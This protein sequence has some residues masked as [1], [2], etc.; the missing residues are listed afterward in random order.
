MAIFALA[1]AVA[2]AAYYGLSVRNSAPLLISQ[3]GPAGSAMPAGAQIDGATT[4]AQAESESTAAPA[5]PPRRTDVDESALRYF[6]AQGDIE[7]LHA[8]IARLR[9]L[10][11]DWLP[12]D[13][14]LDYSR[15]GDPR[16]EALWALYAEGRYDE[17]EA[18]IAR[19]Q[20]TTP[21]FLPPQVLVDS[22]R[23]AKDREALVKASNEGAFATVVDVAAR[24][25]Q[26]LTCAE[27]DVMWRLAEAFAQTD[28]ADR[29]ADAYRFILQNCDDPGERQATVIKASAFLDTAQIESLLMLERRGD[30]GQGEFE[31]VRDDLARAMVSRVANEPDTTVAASYLDRLKTAARR[32]GEPDDSILLGWYSYQRG[33][34]LQARDW[35]R[36]AL[37]S[38]KSPEA[39]QGLA[40]T[41]AELKNYA[42]AE[43]VLYEYRNVS[44]DTIKVYLATVAN[45]LSLEPPKAIAAD[46]LNRMAPVVIE[47]RDVVSAE[48]FGWYAHYL[49]QETTAIDWFRAALSWDPEHEPAAYGLALALNALN[50]DAEVAQ[51]QETWRGRSER[52]ANLG[53]EKDETEPART[54][55]AS[56]P[57][58]SR[59]TTT[60]TRPSTRRAAQPAGCTTTVDMQTISPESALDRGWCLMDLNRTMEAVQAFDRA[61]ASGA[62]ATRK[63]AAYGKS[64]AYLRLKMPDK[65]A[66]A[67]T[68]APQE[69]ARAMELQSAILA[70]RAIGAFR[71]GRYHETII[72]LDQRAR[73]APERQDLMVL[74]A[75]A[76]HNIGRRSDAKRIFQALASVGNKEAMRALGDL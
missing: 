32:D 13:D 34:Y 18:E 53:E 16:I 2:S 49:G 23:L 68:A 33:M 62:Q 10:Y 5:P 36:A 55:A 29:A 42:V 24:S 58:R 15:S 25:P 1:L 28:R 75:F 9:A 43:S 46:V 44:D 50:R 38:L 69:P 47:K 66:A 8:E 51:I 39:A 71:L 35:F 30:D 60:T 41:E 74:R 56:T 12:P 14:P 64:L 3:V 37:D 72:A 73:F 76:Y 19:I 26:L 59:T 6:A 4:S 63:D 65:A 31:A 21:G 17:V 54:A 40:L 22:L 48:Q 45:L 7:R 11:P 61:L 57:A 70:D 27:V 52:I 20:D 67:A